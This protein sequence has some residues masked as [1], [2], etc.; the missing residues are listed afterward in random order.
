ME[1]KIER[2]VQHYFNAPDEDKHSR[3]CMCGKYLT[4]NCHIGWDV[5]YYNTT[6]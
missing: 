6:K 2:I 3:F 1:N 5:D 4:D